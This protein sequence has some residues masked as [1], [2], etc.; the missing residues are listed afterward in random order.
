VHSGKT[1]GLVPLKHDII[2]Q[3]KLLFHFVNGHRHWCVCT[4]VLISAATLKHDY[5]RKRR[6]LRITMLRALLHMIFAAIADAV[7]KLMH[8]SVNAAATAPA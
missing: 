1:K 8:L 7:I 3:R 2:T 6:A 4:R 5:L